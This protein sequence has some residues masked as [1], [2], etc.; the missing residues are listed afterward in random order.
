MPALQSELSYVCLYEGAPSHTEA[1]SLFAQ[2]GYE[3]S[4]TVPVC[5]DDT[6]RTIE[7]DAVMVHPA[8]ML[9]G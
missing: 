6:L 2:H 7:A 3:T 1:L 8:R 4:L 9:V 5:F